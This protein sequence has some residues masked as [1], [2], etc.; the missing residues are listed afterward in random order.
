MRNLAVILKKIVLPCLAVCLCT[1]WNA[2]ERAETW[3]AKVSVDVSVIDEDGG[4]V[5]N[6]EVEVYFGLSVREGATIKGK[7]DGKGMFAARGK[8]TGEIYI[9]AKQKGFLRYFQK[10]RHSCR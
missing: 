1:G 7:T 9:N 2:R 8:T 6:A 4:A 5:S 3:G 10:S